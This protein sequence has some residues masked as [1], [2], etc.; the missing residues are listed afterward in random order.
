MHRLDRSPR[1]FPL[2]PLSPLSSSF[3]LN[4]HLLQDL[5][6]PLLFLSAPLLLLKPFCAHALLG[7]LD[8]LQDLAL[9]LFRSYCSRSHRRGC[10]ES[11]TTGM[12]LSEVKCFSFRL[13]FAEL[14]RYPVVQSC[15]CD[16]KVDRRLE[17]QSRRNLVNPSDTV[18]LTLVLIVH[19]EFLMSLHLLQ[20]DRMYHLA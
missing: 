3:A 11:R 6:F 17:L 12:D 7:Q 4:P 16:R 19:Q 10:Y 20:Q 15:L 2:S 18:R 5:L 1:A 8:L 13:R 9:L 14:D